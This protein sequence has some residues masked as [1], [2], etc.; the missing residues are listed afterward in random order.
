MKEHPGDLLARAENTLRASGLRQ[1]SRE[2]EAKHKFQID[3]AD[4]VNTDI[5]LDSEADPLTLADTVPITLLSE[6]DLLANPFG[7][8][9]MRSLMARYSENPGKFRVVEHST[10]VI[11]LFERASSFVTLLWPDEWARA[12]SLWDE[13][14]SAR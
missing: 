13:R 10:G 14:A 6:H 1:L 12:R 7:L 11:L 9:N 5:L 2:D 8:E 3:T 4:E